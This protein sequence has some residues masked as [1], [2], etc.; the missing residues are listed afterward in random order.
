MKIVH[1]TLATSSPDLEGEIIPVRELERF[2]EQIN[3]QW[4]PMVVEHDPRIPPIGRL[5]SATVIQRDDGVYAVEGTFE[6]Y[7]DGDIIPFVDE[8]RRV[9]THEH[10]NADAFEIRWDRSFRGADDQSD[11]DELVDLL[12]ASNKHHVKKSVEPISALIIAGG[13]ILSGV[14]RG[15]LQKLGGDAA[16]AV[17]KKLKKL[18]QRQRGKEQLLVYEWSVSCEDSRVVIV[19]VILTNPSQED[20]DSFH[21]R[22]QFDLA[23]VL[24]EHLRAP[25]PLA[26]LTYEYENG[27]LELT[28]ALRTDAVPVLPR[29]PES[30]SA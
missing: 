20:I 11:L 24:P 6:R 2:A 3:S 19:Q 5:S 30:D 16:E 17:K 27:K 14:A 29:S 10:M 9:P 13:F 4:L 22:G 8:R 28:Y 26:Q 12:G 25:L 15:F 23:R 21:V 18:M 1:G 7:E